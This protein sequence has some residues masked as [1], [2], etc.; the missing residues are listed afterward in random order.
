MPVLVR[1]GLLYVGDELLVAVLAQK[2]AGLWGNAPADALDRLPPFVGEL[3]TAAGAD[4]TPGLTLEVLLLCPT[5]HRL[6]VLLIADRLAFGGDGPL[7]AVVAQV[8]VDF[9]RDSP[10]RRLGH[11]PPFVGEPRP[12]AD[13]DRTAASHSASFFAA[14]S[15][16]ACRTCAWYSSCPWPLDW[17]R[18]Y[19][20]LADLVDADGV[21]PYIA[22]GVLMDGDDIGKAPAEE[23]ARHLDAAPS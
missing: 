5:T 8:R 6:L 15:W 21:L 10:V 16:A 23:T 19:W 20:V 4:R 18:H 17:Q 1:P 7:L 3:G 11:L 9:L 12:A 2:R 14:C 22:P 13:A